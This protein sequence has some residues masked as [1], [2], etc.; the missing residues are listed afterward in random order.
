MRRKKIKPVDSIIG[1]SWET[2]RKIV[3][4]DATPE[5]I[6][7]AKIAFWSG[8]ASCVLLHDVLASG[9]HT[10]ADAQ[11]LIEQVRREALAFMDRAGFTLPGELENTGTSRDPD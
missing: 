8:W 5:K 10:M 1:K 11:S 6:K 7:N 9:A 4:A 2:Y 3:L